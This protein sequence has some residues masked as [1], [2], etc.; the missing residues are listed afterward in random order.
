MPDY[1]VPDPKTGR[2]IVITSDSPT[3]PT[4]ED[5]EEI[6]T[7][8]RS[9]QPNA[10]DAEPYQ[11]PM[12]EPTDPGHGIT[13]LAP[14]GVELWSA[15]QGVS[16]VGKGLE[17][18]AAYVTNPVAA[19]I[20]G[21]I[22]A[23]FGMPFVGATLGAKLGHIAQPAVRGAGRA[24]QFAPKAAPWAGAVGL[25]SEMNESDGID[26]LDVASLLGLGMTAFPPTAPVGLT[27][28]TGAGLLGGAGEIVKGNTGAGALEMGLSAL[29]W[30][31]K[32]VRGVKAMLP[33]ARAATSAAPAAAGAGVAGKVSS[34]AAKAASI[35]AQSGPAAAGV[36][37]VLSKPATQAAKPLLSQGPQ[38]MLP[39]ADDA[40]QGGITLAPGAAEEFKRLQGMAS[41]NDVTSM[42]RGVANPDYLAQDVVR[43]PR[44]K[45]V[46][47]NDE[48]V[49]GLA[50]E[51]AESQGGKVP[52]RLR[53]YPNPQG[54]S[55]VEKALRQRARIAGAQPSTHGRPTTRRAPAKK[56]KK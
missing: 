48:S 43:W 29:P 19:G 41:P 1:P 31:G 40:A 28:M 38:Q 17:K 7:Q 32:A 53:S 55:E 35:P 25:A 52:T 22:G 20:G 54:A 2:M 27:L 51:L 3:P 45:G 9:F 8:L 56:G 44:A 50:R 21:K 13:G 37:G 4:P 12:E 6:F 24:L 39:F 49:I 10:Q 11:E 15:G 46:L 26:P 23:S 14:E 33:G 42:L 47:R 30:A 34:P 18:G 36:G 16:A 5:V